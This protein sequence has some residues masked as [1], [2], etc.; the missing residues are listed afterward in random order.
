[1]KNTNFWA[2]FFHGKSC[3]ILL[4]KMAWAMHILGDFF[5]N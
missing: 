1:M 2:N 4:K 3:I 5:T